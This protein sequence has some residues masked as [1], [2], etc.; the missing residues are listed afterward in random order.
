MPELSLLAWSLLLAGAIVVGFAKTAIGGAA[1]V[2]VGLFALA[3]PAKESTGTLLLL[4]LV[5]DV[6]GTWAYR[7]TVDRWMLARLVV[8][9][10]VGVGSGVVFLRLVDD[11]VLRRTIGVI[12]LGLLAVQLWT[13]RRPTRAQGSRAAGRAY[14]ALAGF[15]TMVANAGGPPMNLYLLREGMAK[16]TFLGTT[17]WFFFAVNLVKLPFMVALGLVTHRSLVLLP[18][19][20]PAVLLG[21]ALGRW[22]V[23]RLDQVW[24][25]R[26]VTAFVAVSAVELTFF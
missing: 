17:A 26:L 19:L 12:L 24:F 11:Q 5:G 13:L 15:T 18:V 23:G 21:A 25:G 3:L 2:A 1:M 4:L 9:V 6:V 16:W 10:L 20:A 22:A 14:G 7:R 8:P